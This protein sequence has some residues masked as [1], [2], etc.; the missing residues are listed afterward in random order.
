MRLYTLLAR[1]LAWYWR[2]NLAVLLGVAT[3]TGVLGG[4]AL[5]GD[6]VRASLR[7]LVLARLGTTDSIVTRPGFFRQDLAA[8]ATPIIALEGVVGHAAGVEVY[9]MDTAP[10][11]HHPRPRPRTRRQPRRRHPPPHSEALRHPAR[12]PARPQRR[13]HQNHP[14]NRGADRCSEF[15]PAPATRRRPRRVPPAGP[16]AA[17]PEPAR[18]SQHDPADPCSHRPEAALHPGRRRPPR[19]HPRKTRLPFA[20]SRQRPDQRRRGHRRPIARLP[21]PADSD[22][23][24]Q[25]HPRRGERGRSPIR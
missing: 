14:S 24:G 19:P 1:N 4:A 7:D 17:R 13:R 22:L 10:G 2:T 8:A 23:P 12:V 18:K 20:R 21:H 3:A 5:V 15:L 11:P 9:G 16:P 6:S 25:R